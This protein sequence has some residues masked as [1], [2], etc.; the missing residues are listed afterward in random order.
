MLPPPA[1]PYVH[2]DRV[3]VLRGV[4]AGAVRPPVRAGGRRLRVAAVEPAAVGDDRRQAGRA[5]VRLGRRVRRLPGAS[6]ASRR[7]AGVDDE[8][9]RERRA[10][11]R[12][13]GHPGLVA[14]RRLGAGRP[15]VRPAARRRDRPT[16]HDHAR[17]GRVQS[18]PVRGGPRRLSHARRPA[19]GAARARRARNGCRTSPRG[20]PHLGRILRRIGTRRRGAGGV[21][22][23]HRRR[24]RVLDR[25]AV[26]AVE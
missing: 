18:R 16:P 17:V 14:T 10:R 15:R 1:S 12:A 11:R 5:R 13:A 4:R 6:P 3:D 20:R 21:R 26:A 23:A 22:V 2:L 25:I 19:R 8:R 9:H 7:R 24:R